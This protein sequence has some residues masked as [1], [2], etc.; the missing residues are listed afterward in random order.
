[1]ADDAYSTLA[2]KL[3]DDKAAAID[4]ALRA[5]VLEFFSDL[6]RNFAGKKEPKEW[7]ATVEAVQKLKL[8]TVAS[9]PY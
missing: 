5:N 7:R 6:S 1:M 4:P 3:A 9:V 8:S 2:R